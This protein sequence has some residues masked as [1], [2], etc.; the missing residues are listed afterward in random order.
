MTIEMQMS[1]QHHPVFWS[2][3]RLFK[4][5]LLVIC[6]SVIND[7]NLGDLYAMRWMIGSRIYPNDDESIFRNL[8]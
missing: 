6:F 4:V 1:R 2:L 7:E 5:V 8:R 3:I